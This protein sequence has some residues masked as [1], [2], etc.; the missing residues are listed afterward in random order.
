MKRRTLAPPEYTQ[1]PNLWV[2]EWIREVDSLA[3]DKVIQIVMRYTYGWHTEGCE[4]SIDDFQKI[5]GLSRPAIVE[6]IKR[7]LAHGFITREVS[8]HGR[9]YRM[10]TEGCPPSG[11]KSKESELLKE[12]GILTLESKES[13]LLPGVSISVLKKKRKKGAPKPQIRL[14]EEMRTLTEKMRIAGKKYQ[15]E[16]GIDLVIEHDAFVAHSDKNEVTNVSWMGAWHSWLVM[17]VRIKR[18]RDAR[19]PQPTAPAAESRRPLHEQIGE[20]KR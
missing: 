20:K 9:V 17:A 7:A 5:S 12:S 1:V 11:L 18:E 2:D 14:P 4:L 13:E 3:E 15:D 19:F 8:G 16:E 10:P 6:G